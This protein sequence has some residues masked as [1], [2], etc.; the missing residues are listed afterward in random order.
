MRDILFFVP[1]VIVLP[2]IAE[3]HQAGTGVVALLYAP[4]IADVL[5]FFIALGITIKLFKQL[6]KYD[7]HP[8]NVG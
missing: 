5:A 8:S 4:M 7:K 2:M 3:K 6:K 1:A